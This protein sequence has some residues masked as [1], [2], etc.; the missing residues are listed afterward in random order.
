MKTNLR[1]AINIGKDTEQKLIA[2]GIDSLE[3]LCSIGSE[4][5]FLRLKAID[6]GACMSL[7]YGLEGAITGIK[8]NNLPDERKAALQDFHRMCNR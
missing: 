3:K 7:L 4:Q 2:V 6:P 8:W 1:N 5:A